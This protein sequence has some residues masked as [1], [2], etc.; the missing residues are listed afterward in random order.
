MGGGE[1][2]LLNYVDDNA[3]IYQLHVPLEVGHEV[4]SAA[5]AQFFILSVLPFRRKK[6]AVEKKL[7]KINYHNFKGEDLISKRCL[8]KSYKRDLAFSDIARTVWLDWPKSLDTAWQHSQ[9]EFL[10]LQ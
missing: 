8:F 5:K 10:Q 2:R 9:V 4:R 3:K 7:Q 6:S 1:Q